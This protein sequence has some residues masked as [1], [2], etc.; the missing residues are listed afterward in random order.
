VPS[1]A[2]SAFEVSLQP[3][4]LWIELTSKCPLDCVFCS[5]QARRGIGEHMPLPLVKAILGDLHEPELIRLNYAGESANYPGLGEAIA[6]ASATGAA[7]EL[8]SALVSAPAHA[9]REMVDRGLE[10]LSVS[11][12]TTRADAFE[13]IYRFGNYAAVV[14]K[15]AYLREYRASVGRT[16]PRL[17]FAFVAMRR[18]LDQLQPVA[19]V[20]RREGAASVSVHPVIAREPLLRPAFLGEIDEVGE[21]RDGFWKALESAVDMARE[22]VPEVEIAIARPAP[23]TLSP[24]AGFPTCEQNPWETAHILADGS[25]VPCE[26]Q[27]HVVL[28]SVNQQPLG[29]IW[30]GE[31]YA[32]FRDEYRHGRNVICNGCPWRTVAETDGGRAYLRGWHGPEKDGHRWSQREALLEVAVGKGPSVLTIEGLLPVDAS[33]N[34]VVAASS[35]GKGAYTGHEPGIAPFRLSLP[36]GGS[37]SLNELIHIK[38]YRRFVPAHNGGEDLRGLGIGLTGISMS[39]DPRRLREVRTLLDREKAMPIEIAKAAPA[40][41]SIAVLIPAR[42]YDPQLAIAVRS[43]IAAAAPEVLVVLSGECPAGWPSIAAANPEAI[44]MFSEQPLTFLRAV[45]RG[46]GRLRSGW[47][48]LLNSDMTLDA[49]AIREAALC[50][51]PDVFAI[52]SRIR[53]ADGSNTETNF[54]ELRQPVNGVA[55]I[56]EREVPE[57]AIVSECAY[58]GGGSALFQRDLL[59]R[60]ARESRCYEPFYWEDVEWGLRARTAGYRSLFCPFSIAV[61]LRRHTVSRF[62]SDAEAERIFERNRLFFH[63]RNLETNSGLEGALCDLDALSWNE[64]RQVFASN[65]GFYT[66]PSQMPPDG[67]CGPSP[68]PNQQPRKSLTATAGPAR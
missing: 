30:H 42:G 13:E 27:D 39:R 17:D 53:M 19:E 63:L 57:A 48:Y 1:L 37:G 38:T 66:S 43:A 11:L 51:A 9:L 6:L 32:R 18:N 24:A 65:S 44:W 7:T 46:L 31:S 54:T 59:L 22:R 2:H 15:L 40:E 49:D 28:G 52:G 34:R 4:F 56:F 60:L 10:R 8:V 3:R 21:I 47:V 62:Y 58:A 36:V 16:N 33:G 50:R 61:H 64:I 68:L 29:E 67:A 35:Q 26:V 12:H 45:L 55:E 41:D 25:V 20:A 14:A 23:R 5:R